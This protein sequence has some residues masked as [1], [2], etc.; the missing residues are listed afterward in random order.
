MDACPPS[1][2]T[3]VL[4]SRDCPLGPIS[5]RSTLISPPLPD[6]E[7]HLITLPKLLLFLRTGSML[8]TTSAAQRLPQPTRA[9]VQSLRLSP[10][11]CHLAQ[12]GLCHSAAGHGQ[13]KGRLGWCLVTGEGSVTAG[14][15]PIRAA[16]VCCWQIMAAVSEEREQHII[17]NL[18]KSCQCVPGPCLFLHM[19]CPPLNA[20]F[21]GGVISA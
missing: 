2:P 21:I 9:R 20:A 1:C 3:P 12:R 19:A 15:S 16:S 8:G 4:L 6:L 14:V 13:G 7:Q 18:L 5:C 17:N 10:A 11:L